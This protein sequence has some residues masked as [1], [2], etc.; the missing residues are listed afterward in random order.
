MAR[1]A[2]DFRR[3]RLHSSAFASWLWFLQRR[4]H[5]L[6]RLSRVCAVLEALL[7]KRA[8]FALRRLKPR[9]VQRTLKP[10]LVLTAETPVITLGI[11][12]TADVKHRPRKQRPLPPVPLC[13]CLLR[14]S[15]DASAT[16]PLPSRPQLCEA[17]HRDHFVRRLSA[18]NQLVATVPDDGRPM[19]VVHHEC[20]C[21]VE[22]PPP[23]R[24]Q[25]RHNYAVQ[26]K[27]DE[28]KRMERLY[29]KHHKAKKVHV[30][31]VKHCTTVLRASEPALPLSQSCDQKAFRWSV[32]IPMFGSVGKLMSK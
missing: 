12:S 13:G 5:A 14:Y 20:H 18:A 23:P 21:K 26:R 10:R 19:F 9:T 7:Y 29:G 6:H 1:T 28:M 3:L 8:L 30:E 16:A 4:R 25:T 17:L 31:G 15:A 24:P 22:P 11:A 2:A 32:P 27:D